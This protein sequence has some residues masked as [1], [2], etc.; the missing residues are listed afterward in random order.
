MATS[1]L[2]ESDLAIGGTGGGVGIPGGKWDCA[3]EEEKGRIPVKTAAIWVLGM[4][5]TYTSSF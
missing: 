5:C 4:L 1:D 3:P 2:R